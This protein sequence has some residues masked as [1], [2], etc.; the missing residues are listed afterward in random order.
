LSVSGPEYS[1]SLLTDAFN[2]SSTEEK[3]DLRLKVEM[4]NYK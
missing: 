4:R 3:S 2:I 1:Y